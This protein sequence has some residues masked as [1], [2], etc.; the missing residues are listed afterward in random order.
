MIAIVGF[1]AGIYVM[2]TDALKLGPG[3]TNDSDYVNMAQ[4][5]PE[6]KAF[7][8]HY[9]NAAVMVN[10]KDNLTVDFTTPLDK[11]NSENTVKLS[12][13]FNKT[14]NWPDKWKIEYSEKKE[15]TNVSEIGRY[16][17]LRTCVQPS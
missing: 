17:D 9:P 6:A 2:K 7:L 1:V 15:F 5:T 12:V 4:K 3:N 16:L 8:Q 13:D 11:N 10:R 14:T